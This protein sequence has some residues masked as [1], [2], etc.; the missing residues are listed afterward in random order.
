M[1]YSEGGIIIA[2]KNHACGGSK[3]KILRTGADVKLKCLTCGHVL[4]LSYD[5]LAKIVKDYSQ[6]GEGNV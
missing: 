1:I 6:S 3:W 5:K 2:R 4:I